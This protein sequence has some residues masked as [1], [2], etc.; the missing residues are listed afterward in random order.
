M[1]TIEKP[2]VLFGPYG[3]VLEERGRQNDCRDLSLPIN[4]LHG[5]QYRQAV[6][7]VAKGY[8][9]V[10]DIATTNS[11]GLRTTLRNGN[12]QLYREALK[13]HY[14]VVKEAVAGQ[15][16]KIFVCLGP[17]G[18]CYDPGESPDSGLA[19]DFHAEQ[20]AAVKELDVVDAILF[21]TLC[22]AKEAVGIALAAKEMDAKVIISFVIDKVGRL[23][24]GETLNDA[25]AQVEAASGSFP[26]GYSVN[27]CPV[28]G[29]WKA[30]D[31]SNGYR[32]RIVAAYPNASSKDPRELETV[33]GIVK[34]IDH[35][36]H[37]GELANIA[38]QNSNI[39]IV[40]GCCGFDH[41]SVEILA[42][43][44]ARSDR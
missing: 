5:G 10:A 35:H 41:Q 7:D 31:R 22:T 21:E 37:A 32:Q 4:V 39:A 34:D 15:R 13:A 33:D 42:R 8:A 12:E 29:V 6:L 43:K 18:N 28:E 14:D 11:F 26:Q 38:L 20:L 27:C 40:G 44:I 24:S 36:S 23:L 3:T 19:H 9:A 25:I 30:L 16:K 2:D 1:S 17:Y